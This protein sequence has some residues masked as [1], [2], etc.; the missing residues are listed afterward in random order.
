MTE[1]SPKAGG[2]AC[3]AVRFSTRGAPKRAGL[4]HCMTCRKAHAAAFNPF[5]VFAPDQVEV[6]GEVLAWESSPG[7]RRWFCPACGSR[8]FAV[9]AAGAGGA[10]YEISLG[11]Y[12]EPGLF[13]PTYESWTLRREPWLRPLPGPQHARNRPA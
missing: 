10:E 9:N 5:L 1:P 11:S 12:D 3:G 2:C 7:Y 8:V 6:I 13:E 4:C